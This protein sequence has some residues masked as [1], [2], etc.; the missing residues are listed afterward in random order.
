MVSHGFAMWRFAL[1]RLGE[2]EGLVETWDDW[3]HD[4]KKT[5]AYLA[6]ITKRHDIFQSS[7]GCLEMAKEIHPSA[8]RVRPLC[9]AQIEGL[10]QTCDAR[11]TSKKVEEWCHLD[12]KLGAVDETADLKTSDNLKPLRREELHPVIGFP[13]HAC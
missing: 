12:V 2:T 11:P 5:D 8:G 6:M 3:D 10:E 4:T 13:P 9:W 7:F 1:L